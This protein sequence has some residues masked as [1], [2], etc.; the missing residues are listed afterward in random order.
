M[1][2]LR[3]S[4]VVFSFIKTDCF[5][6]TASSSWYRWYFS[7][8]PSQSQWREKSNSCTIPCLDSTVI[9]IPGSLS[10]MKGP[11]SVSIPSLASRMFLVHTFPC[12]K[13]LS[14]C[15]RAGKECSEW[16]ELC[17][18]PWRTCSIREQKTPNW[19]PKIQLGRNYP[20]EKQGK[21][22]YL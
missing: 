3:F 15:S 14:S 12:T 4:I 17:K 5:Y 11:Y 18:C 16:A 21:V 8:S 20:R 9:G 1:T 7:L 2:L 10:F 13:S 6:C 22:L 19:N